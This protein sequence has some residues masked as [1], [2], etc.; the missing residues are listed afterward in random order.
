MAIKRGM[1]CVLYYGTAGSTAD[2]VADNVKD[3]TLNLETGEADVTTRGN[4]GWRATMATLKDGA[5]EFEAIWD[6]DDAFF[7]ALQTAYFAGTSIALL[8]LNDTIAAGGEGL[9]ADFTITNFS[10]NESLE[11]AVTASVTCKP[12]YSTRAPDW[13][14]AS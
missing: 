7:T 9:D 3:L 14:T 4:E 2:T 5:I 10:R 6:N 11:E 12:A 1:D 13:Y 8:A